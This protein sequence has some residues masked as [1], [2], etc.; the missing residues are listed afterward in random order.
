VWQSYVVL[1]ID[2]ERCQLRWAPPPTFFCTRCN[3]YQE[4]M[5]NIKYH[6][7]APDAPSTR[8]SISVICICCGKKFRTMASLAKHVNVRGFIRRPILDIASGMS[9]SRNSPAPCGAA[10]GMV[11]PPPTAKLYPLT[12]HHDRPDSDF[13]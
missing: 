2:L 8:E 1:C 5:Q 10:A 9:A 4:S 3:V 12:S 13:H 6:V 11:L 7:C